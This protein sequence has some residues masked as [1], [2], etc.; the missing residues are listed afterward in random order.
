MAL[1]VTIEISTPLPLMEG[2]HIVTRRL[3]LRIIFQ[4][5]SLSWRETEETRQL[6]EYARISTPLPFME[7][8][9]VTHF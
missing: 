5:L 1:T 9:D 6:L 3:L 7:G 8:D 2:D 4:H